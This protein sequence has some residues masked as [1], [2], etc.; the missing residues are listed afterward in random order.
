MTKVLILSNMYPSKESPYFGVFVKEQ[1]DSLGAGCEIGLVTRKSKSIIGYFGLLFRL[2]SALL[3]GN[4]SV[5]HV[6][7]GLTA[8]SVFPVLPLLWLK[9]IKLVLT[10]HGSDVLGSSFIVRK[11]TALGIYFSSTTIAVSMQIYNHILKYHPNKHVVWLPCGIDD[12]FFD[13]RASAERTLTVVFPSNPKRVEKNFP[14]FIRVLKCVEAEIG[15]EVNIICLIGKSRQEIQDIFRASAC[16]FMTSL[17]EGSPQTVKEAVASGLPVVSTD[18][19]D[20]RLILDG[21]NGCVVSDDDEIL[22]DGII[23]TLNSLSSVNY[24]EDFVKQYKQSMV[25]KRVLEIYER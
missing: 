13:K 1:V 12:S 10:L 23:N 19:G 14:R 7:Y 15:R 9:G 18:V 8:I 16:L 24:P 5:L 6:H 2:M 3:F 22:K 21:I 17:Y 25:C 20:V 4:Y 11:I